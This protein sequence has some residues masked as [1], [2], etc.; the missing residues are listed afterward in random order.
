MS[1]ATP[2][3]EWSDILFHQPEKANCKI[4]S[5]KEKY[6]WKDDS[7]A[8]FRNLSSTNGLILNL[9]FIS[10]VLTNHSKLQSTAHSRPKKEEKLHGNIHN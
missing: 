8:G 5:I 6:C 9:L 10:F 2:E 4:T 1:Q 7:L 3:K